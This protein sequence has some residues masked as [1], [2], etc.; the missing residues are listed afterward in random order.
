ME[1]ELRHEAEVLLEEG[2]T[3]ALIGGGELQLVTVRL[4]DGPGVLDERGEP[5]SS[6]GVAVHLPPR[7]GAHARLRA[8]SGCLAREAKSA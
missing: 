3:E 2:Q 7:G 5:V 4:F 1:A 6:A 8:A